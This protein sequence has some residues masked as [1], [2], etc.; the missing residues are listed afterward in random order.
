MSA[1]PTLSLF[2]AILININIM[3]G[4]GIFINTV[5]ITKNAGALGAAVYAL[6]GILLLP[7]IF[8]FASLL[9]HFK[10]G[11]FYDFGTAISKRWGFL[12]SWCYFTAKLSSCALGIHV[13]SSL[14]Q[15]I[16]PALLR[17][18]TLS[19]DCTIILCFILL[20]SLNLR[21]GH[22][23]QFS[24]MGLKLIPI[25]F[26]VISGIYL[27]TGGSFT[28]SQ[29]V[30]SGIPSSIPFVLYAFTGFEATCSLSRSIRNPEKNGPKAV[31]IAYTIGVGLV[32]LY[33]FLFF[34]ALGAQLGSL[35]SYLEA[36]PALLNKLFTTNTTLQIPLKN[37]LHIGIA[38]SALGA[39]YGILYSNAWNLHALA[40]EGHVSF[41][42]VFTKLNKHHVPFAC[43]LAEGALVLV[44]T[45][46]AQG[47]QVPLQQISSFGMTLTYTLSTCALFYVAA[48]SRV[49]KLIPLLGLGSCALLFG[50]I[51]RSVILFGWMPLGV[52]CSILLL[53]L[54]MFSYR[55]YMHY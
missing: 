21:I 11:T 1:A 52:F 37:F 29:L 8:T 33:Q 26:A 23:V 7:L 34:G 44:Y 35:S 36:F 55:K 6:V 14:I 17:F 49:N 13:F 42:H 31:L 48:P 5:L 15:T 41:K 18:S 4:T 2:S 46:V 50:G 54:C 40:T 28:E 10:G 47:N 3:L 9:K 30:W 24:F 43:I 16:F 19:I 53:G 12:S 25:I 20:N 27:F 45:F 38:S 39:A 32:V 51:V 22:Y